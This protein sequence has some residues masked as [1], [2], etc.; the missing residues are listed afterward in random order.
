M[1]EPPDRLLKLAQV[2][3][4]VGL[5]RS[6]VYRLIRAGEFPSP[7]KPGGFAS[8]W[9][10]AEIRAWRSKVDDERRERAA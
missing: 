4:I 7:H 6:M 10:E 8:R 1:N 2:L 9:S 3:E 5:G